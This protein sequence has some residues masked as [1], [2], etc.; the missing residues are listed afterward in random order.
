M[1]LLLLLE[2]RLVLGNPQRPSLAD[3]PVE[4]HG[5][6]ARKDRKP[7]NQRAIEACQLP[8]LPGFNNP[9]PDCVT[10]DRLSTR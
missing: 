7:G 10:D 5:S 4:I 3:D 1:R 9:I 8:F 6:H 2:H